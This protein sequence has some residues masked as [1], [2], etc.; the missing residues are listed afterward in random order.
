MREYYS[1]A[2]FAETLGVSKNT[3]YQWIYTGAI[4]A[5]QAKRKGAQRIPASELVRLREQRNN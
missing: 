2:E 5:V 3:V 4:T 1:V